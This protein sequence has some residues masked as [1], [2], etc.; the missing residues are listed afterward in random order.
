MSKA[1]ISA[2]KRQKFLLTWRVRTPHAPEQQT[3]HATYELV[4]LQCEYGPL[5]DFVRNPL[6][7]ALCSKDYLDI[8]ERNCPLL[9]IYSTFM[10]PCGLVHATADYHGS[11]WSVRYVSTGRITGIILQVWLYRVRNRGGRW[12]RTDLR[13]DTG[14]IYVAGRKGPE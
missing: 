6:R 4:S 12:T 10:L 8:A 2:S 13:Q 1:A 11:E 5:P 14:S 9:S 7:K 3:R